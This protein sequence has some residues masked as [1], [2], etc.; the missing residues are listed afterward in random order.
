MTPAEQA[1]ARR[2]LQSMIQALRNDDEGVSFLPAGV[3]S[4]AGGM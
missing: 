1:G 2:I 3:K 4:E